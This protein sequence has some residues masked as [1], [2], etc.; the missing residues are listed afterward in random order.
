MKSSIKVRSERGMVLLVVLV[1]LTVLSSLM[2]D[3]GYTTLVDLRLTETFRDST[4]AYY[5]AKGGI[6]AGQM[7][8]KND[9]NNYDSLTEW[10][11]QPIVNFPIQEGNVSIKID[12]LGG[13]LDLNRL[14]TSGGNPD[15]YVKGRVIRLLDHL[16]II[17]SESITDA[18]IDWIDEDETPSTSGAE[19][20]YYRSLSPAYESKNAPFD[21][22]KE[23]LMVRGIDNETLE[24]ISPHVTIHG[25]AKINVNTATDAVL[26]A[27]VPETTTT[28]ADEIISLRSNQAITQLGDLKQIG[29][30]N[31]WYYALKPYIQVKSDNYRIIGEGYVGDAQKRVEAVVEKKTKKTI[32]WKVF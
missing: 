22:L 31:D 17:D 21:T 23:L 25:Q 1:L 9:N 24:L 19:S 29:N 10:W 28:D 13:K 18:L 32:Y 7:V 30:F 27:W 2:I 8:L 5:L 26:V 15:A 4:K 14:M 11:A 20:N 6:E 12:D 16:D 3:L